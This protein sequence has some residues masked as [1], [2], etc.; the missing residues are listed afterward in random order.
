MKL[1]HAL[2]LLSVAGLLSAQ[3]D[4]RIGEWNSH[5]P[6]LTITHVETGDGKTF[7]GTDESVL[8]VDQDDQS[9]RF[10]SKVDG[11]SDASI[12]EMLYDDRE[13]QLII[14]YTSSAIDIVLGSEV[15]TV[16]D[17]RDKS[18]IQGDKS[19]YDLYVDDNNFL[20]LATGFGL[21]QYDLTT[22]EF[23]FTLDI[24]ARV[25][26]VSGDGT[27]LVITTEDGAYALDLAQTNAPAFFQEW[28]KLTEGLPQDAVP[29]DVYQRGS[30]IY[31]AD[32]TTLYRSDSGSAFSPIYDAE[33]DIIFIH[34]VG[35]GGYLVGDKGET[36]PRSHVT[37][38]S[39]ND[40]Q[41]AQD[42]QCSRRL[43]DASLDDE[44]RLF[45]A[46]EWFTVRYK[47]INN[48]N[49]CK[50]YNINSPL[51]PTVSDMAIKDG[52]IYFA[53]GGVTENFFNSNSREG[54]YILDEDEWTLV[55]EF[56]EDFLEDFLELHQVA[57]HPRVSK[58]YFASFF[59]GLL[60]YDPVSEEMVIYDDTNSPL[61]RQVGDVRVRISGL[62][63]D[64]EGNLW[65]S[66][67]SAEDPI[68]V[69]TPEGVWHSFQLPSSPDTKVTEIAVDDNDFV[70]VNIW[71]S[72]GGL[73]VLDRG[74]TLAD[75][76]DDRQRFF[77]ISNS[78]LES[79]FLFDL[80]KDNDGA[81]WV[82]TGAGAVVFDCG[83]SPF[84]V[85]TCR[86]SRRRT[87]T[88]SIT[89]FLLESEE[90]LSIETDGANRK[91]FGT[92]NGIFV[93]GP[94]GEEKIASFDE[95]TS[96]LFDNNVQDMFFEPNSGVMYIATN[97]GLQSLR[98][99][100]TGARPIHT[101]DVYAFPN[102]V[103]PDYSGPIAIKGLAQDAEV[104]ITDIDGKLVFKT[105]ALGGQAIWDG[106]NLEGNAVSGG[107]YLVYS[108]TTDF[109]QDID[110]YVTKILVIR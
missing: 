44:D 55:N 48:P 40:E 78:E 84:D 14:A 99:E 3:S 59:A 60:E 82:G 61:Q 98:T 79:N 13:D 90:V 45:L 96:P 106:F 109:F 77:N 75:P 46:D 42:E 92:R 62:D 63:F 20:Y 105:D 31:V 39:D 91:W 65:I 7:Y 1:L 4:L 108:S 29:A 24:S 68:A 49:E 28:E 81:I 47:N 8:I 21:V 50:L 34:Q 51:G 88:D 16:K 85:E 15:F 76:S 36:G 83:G 87:Q 80:E 52:K 26:R 103:R 33:F 86:G 64:S 93:Q 107:V 67:F 2:L 53:S 70:W 66:N 6:Y 37:Y 71:G 104:S 72:A 25:N 43:L 69:L 11:L 38:F 57:A 18:D 74:E 95:E 41:L 5:L 22:L 27:S 58:I 73:V 100:T 23:G 12:S 89:A 35:K 30:S 102:P 97:N 19:I 101:N 110:T 56:E 17:I 54:F 10:L 32:A 9:F 94:N